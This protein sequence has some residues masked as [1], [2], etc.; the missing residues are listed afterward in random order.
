MTKWSGTECIGTGRQDINDFLSLD[1][2]QENKPKRVKVNLMRINHVSLLKQTLFFEIIYSQFSFTY[3]LF[4]FGK[5]Q[6]KLSFVLIESK[7]MRKCLFQLILLLTDKNKNTDVKK[8]VQLLNLIF[9]RTVEIS[10]LNCYH[11]FGIL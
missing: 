2:V 1:T 11:Y 8:W 4:F 6:N 5:S 7:R 3:I 9:F 10:K